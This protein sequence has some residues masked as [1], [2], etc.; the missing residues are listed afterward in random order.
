MPKYQDWRDIGPVA[1]SFSSNIASTWAA[2]PHSI[3]REIKD[4]MQAAQSVLCG[5]DDM[6]GAHVREKMGD[7]EVN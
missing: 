6:I 4:A 7:D 1:A 5:L 3:P 2:N